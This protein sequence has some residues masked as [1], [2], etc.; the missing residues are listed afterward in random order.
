MRKIEIWD[1]SEDNVERESNAIKAKFI[2]QKLSFVIIISNNKILW[3]WLFYSLWEE[4]TIRDE[5]HSSS[6]ELIA[7]L[8]LKFD[9]VILWDY[10]TCLKE[11]SLTAARWHCRKEI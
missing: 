5:N 6:I 2:S 9:L 3:K 10:P 8:L 1:Y 11:L 7:V 4:S